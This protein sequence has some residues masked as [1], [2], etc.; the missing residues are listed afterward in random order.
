[1]HS[2][3]ESCMLFV[4]HLCCLR[5]ARLTKTA[6]VVGDLL[7]LKRAVQHIAQSQDKNTVLEQPAREA[8]QYLAALGAQ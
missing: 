6:N 7:Q 1:M 4:H 3:R 2:Y 5:L 8:L